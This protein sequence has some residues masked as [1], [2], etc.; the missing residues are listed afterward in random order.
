MSETE[1]LYKIGEV[2]DLLA[3]SVRAIRYYEE[4]GLITPERSSRGTRYYSK[5]HIARLRTIKKMTE[6][7]FALEPIK[8]LAK[9]REQQNT[10]DLSQKAVRAQLDEI[11]SEIH[12]Q[13]TQ[14]QQLAS[15]LEAAKSKIK[16]CAGC[17]NNPTSKGCPD[18]PVRQHLSQIELLNLIWDQEAE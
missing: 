14:L 9:A 17:Q 11:E 12:Q 6:S 5:H 2:A 16:K 18:C 13:M 4:E 3:T 8:N 7:G 10:G 1:H 15:Q